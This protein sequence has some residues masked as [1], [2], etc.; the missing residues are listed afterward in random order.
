V[1]TAVAKDRKKRLCDA[2]ALPVLVLSGLSTVDQFD[3]TAFALLATEIAAAFNGLL[4][5]EIV[6]VSHTHATTF[7]F[8]LLP[9]L[10]LALV[11]PLV[12]GYIAD[13]TSRVRLTIVG[14]VL[15][16]ISGFLSGI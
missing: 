11:L 13:R 4:A 2:P 6:A 16:V 8:I 9:Q 15:W 12:F 1:V 14:A 10:R 3:T 7:G 5:P